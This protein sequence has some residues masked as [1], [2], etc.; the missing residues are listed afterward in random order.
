MDEREDDTNAESTTGR[1][2]ARWMLRALDLAT[3]LVIGAAFGVMGTLYWYTQTE[4]VKRV[5]RVEK[6]ATMNRE[7]VQRHEYMLTR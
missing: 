6:T 1:M 7:D 4:L 3:A 5:E 2:I